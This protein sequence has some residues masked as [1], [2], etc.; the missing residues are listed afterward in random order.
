MVFGEKFITQNEQ[1]LRNFLILVNIFLFPPTSVCFRTTKS[2]S[3]PKILIE[4][5]KIC[6]PEPILI[7]DN[8]IACVQGFATLRV[9]PRLPIQNYD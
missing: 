8:I 4:C 9:A 6:V 5:S 7:S 1:N 2:I 3:W